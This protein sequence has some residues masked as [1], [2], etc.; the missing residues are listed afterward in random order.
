MTPAGSPTV[1][2]GA[3]VVTPEAVLPAGWVAIANGVIEAVGT[4]TPPPGK[5]HELD[6]G[7]LL[8]GFIDLHVHGGGG[9]DVTASA[10]D[11]AASLAFHRRH[12]TTASLVSL[13]SA[14]IDTLCA[15][16]SLVAEHASRAGPGPLL[17]GA[18][19]E[20]PFLSQAHRG[21]H[22]PA[23]LQAP[24]RGAVARL[25]EAAGGWLAC[26]TI[27]PELPGALEVIE[28]LVAA[29]VVA[30]IGHTDANYEQARAAFD[31]GASLATHLFN[32]MR[33]IHHR[34]PGPVLAALDSGAGCEVINDG[35]HVHP[36]V[37]REVYA[38]G[39]DRLVLVTDA[40]AAAGSGRRRLRAR[41]PGCH[42]RRRRGPAERHRRAGRQH[43]DDG[44]GRPTRR[45]RR[46][47]GH[48]RGPAPRRPIRPGSSAS[49][50]AAGRFARAWPPNWCTWT[51]TSSFAPSST[52]KTRGIPADER[53]DPAATSWRCPPVAAAGSVVAPAVTRHGVAQSGAGT[54]GNA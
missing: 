42:G 10:A 34:D 11:L 41:R 9:H 13:V 1:L 20:G 5:R 50:I 24:D 16:L 47:A 46:A 21:A 23:Y 53:T 29:G 37:L 17:L 54:S 7:W 40:M 25:I 45:C 33:A 12:G 35:V 51:T 4:G 26:M 39:A 14:P 38:R 18:H 43:P 36:A 27:A 28:D 44:S 3:R 52:P 2:C 30:A 49:D 15:Q 22:D 32:G 8:P 19:L 48:S 6:G 31:R